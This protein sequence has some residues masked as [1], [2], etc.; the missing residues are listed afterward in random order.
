M[1][2]MFYECNS[3]T[4]IDSFNFNTQNITNMSYMFDGWKIFN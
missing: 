4:N 1:T 3:L 2:G